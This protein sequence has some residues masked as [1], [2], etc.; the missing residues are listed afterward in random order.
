MFSEFPEAITE[1]AVSQ[2]GTARGLCSK[3]QA[4]PASNSLQYTPRCRNQCEQGPRPLEVVAT[5]PSCTL[6]VRDH[7]SRTDTL[8]T[9]RERSGEALHSC[10][11]ARFTLQLPWQTKGLGKEYPNHKHTLHQSTQRC[12]WCRLQEPWGKE[13]VMSRTNGHTGP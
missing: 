9:R 4:F 1:C 3:V 8:T 5:D 13:S 7:H 11:R 2:T 10:T 12:L 6:C